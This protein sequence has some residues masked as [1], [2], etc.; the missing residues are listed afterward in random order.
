MFWSS[1]V[2]SWSLYS[3]QS[4]VVCVVSV[5]TVLLFIFPN[6]LLGLKWCM[7]PDLMVWSLIINHS[8]VFKLG[9]D[10]F[11]LISWWLYLS[12]CRV[13]VPQ[14]EAIMH[15]PVNIGDYTDFYSSL[16]HAQNVG[17]MFRPGQ[18][19]LLPNW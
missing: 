7:T 3:P 6:I 13:F 1:F 14:N 15:M 4:A 8:I 17:A 16:H 9:I 19:A 18:A 11:W 2:F 12:L 5:F 10:S